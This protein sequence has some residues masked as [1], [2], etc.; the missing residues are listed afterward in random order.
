MSGATVV[1]NGT[2]V[3]VAVPLQPEAFQSLTGV[4]RETQDRLVAYV[5]ILKSWNRRINLVGRTTLDDPWRRHVWDAAQLL[6]LV[7]PTTRGLVDLGSGAGIPGLILAILGVPAVHLVESDQRKCAFLR[8]AAR[9]CGVTGAVTIHPRRIEAM[10][11]LTADVVTARALAPLPVLLDNAARFTAPHT[12]CL[13]LKG[14]QAEAELTEAHNHWTMTATTLPSVT[15][16]GG[17]I[18][19]LEHLARDASAPS[20]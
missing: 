2:A 19:R 3:V 12:I 10:P 7:P 8:E 20:A 1:V 9:Q 16:P 4:S 15:D 13:F 14:K 5:A 18:L 11:P 17:V 6:P